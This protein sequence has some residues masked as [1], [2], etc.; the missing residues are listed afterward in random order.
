M[1]DHGA[2]LGVGKQYLEDLSNPAGLLEVGNCSALAYEAQTNDIEL[3]DYTNPGGG[4][5]ASVTRI[6]GVNVTY[7]ARHFK[8]A[9][10][11]RALYGAVDDVEAGTVTGEAH[12]AFPGGLLL[13]KNPGASDLVIKAGSTTLVEGTDYVVGPGGLP[14]MKAS[15]AVIE[16]GVD[17]TV[18]YSYAARAT[19][20]A[21]VASGKRFRSVFV[22]LNEADSG[23]PVIIEVFRINHSPASLSAI[24]DEFAGM[25]FTAKAEKD[26]SKS[27]QGVSQYMTVTFL[28]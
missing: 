23:R 25:E 1:K 4:L 26:A 2:Y 7:T 10:V 17:V 28:D 3:Q 9:N 13:L 19:V 16:A 21:L 12:R 14:A 15:T 20:Q 22:G 5:D 6:T 8:M 24:G 18:D 27:G 11:A